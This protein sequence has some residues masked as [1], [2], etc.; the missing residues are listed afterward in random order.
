MDRAKAKSMTRTVQTV[1]AALV[2]V[3]VAAAFIPFTA[4]ADS[5]ESTAPPPPPPKPPESA[6]ARVEID[7]AL[8]ATALNAVSGPVK[9][10][11]VEPEPETG[12]PVTQAP[13]TGL[14]AWRYLGAIMSSS[15]K[16]AI[17]TFNEQQHLLAE[18]QKLS[19]DPPNTPAEAHNPANDV[20]IVQIDKLF[21]KVKQG[22]VEKQ[23]DLA[24]RQRAALNVLDPAAARAAAAAGNVNGV[25]VNGNQVTPGV[26]SAAARR[27]RDLDRAKN[28]AKMRGDEK[29]AAMYDA[30]AADAAKEGKLEKGEKGAK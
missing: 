30:A 23:I 18:G 19:L 9:N 10:Q 6:A 16:R 15:Y 11:H 25:R 2:L 8:L 13:V 26:E 27:A 24:P 22:E 3:A 20:E 28:D 14:D 21:I 1:A 29:S 12:T 7:T 5:T 4:K 17:V